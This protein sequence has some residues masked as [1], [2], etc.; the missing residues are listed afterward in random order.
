[1]RITPIPVNHVVPTMGFLLQEGDVAVILSIDTGPTDELWRCAN[2]LPKLSAV[3]LEVTFPNSM[4]QLALLAKHLTPKTFGEEV[5]KL[6]CPSKIVAIHIKPAFY[7][8]VV[9]ELRA[10]NLPDLEIGVPGKE[11]CF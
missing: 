5:A 9:A 3:F 11:Y 4:D 7:D 2:A 8:Q 6:S 1:M 10:L